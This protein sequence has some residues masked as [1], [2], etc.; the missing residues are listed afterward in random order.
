MIMRINLSFQPNRRK[1]D[2]TRASSYG[3]NVVADPQAPSQQSR[4][5]LDGAT[6]NL[7]GARAPVARETAPVY[8]VTALVRPTA[9]VI[10]PIPPVTGLTAPLSEVTGLTQRM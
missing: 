7:D 8:L 3:I 5:I 6:A 1:I 2:N 4:L 10:L 9:P